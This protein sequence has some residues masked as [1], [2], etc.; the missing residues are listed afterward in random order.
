MDSTSETNSPRVSGDHLGGRPNSDGPD[1]GSPM[2]LAT[3][4][5]GAVWVVDFNGN[6]VIDRLGVSDGLAY[7]VR[8]DRLGR[9]RASRFRSPRSATSQCIAD[10]TSVGIIKRTTRP[11][12]SLT[13]GTRLDKIWNGLKCSCRLNDQSLLPVDHRTRRFDIRRN[14]PRHLA[15]TSTGNP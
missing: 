2:F 11:S 8:Y 15:S 5:D 14:R 9:P 1:D 4:P 13:I 7:I 6:E 12:S 3:A 10:G